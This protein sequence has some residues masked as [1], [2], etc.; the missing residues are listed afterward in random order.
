MLFR[1]LIVASVLLL[2]VVLVAQRVW[3]YVT[4]EPPSRQMPAAVADVEERQ[5]FQSPK[6][7]Y[8]LADIEAN[9]SELPSE[10]YR[11]FKARHDFHPKPDDKLCPITRTK[12]NPDCTW[13]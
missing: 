5:L 13:I 8:L 9:G 1:R 10:R 4:F 12:A 11:G 3:R 6:G 7:I 2:F